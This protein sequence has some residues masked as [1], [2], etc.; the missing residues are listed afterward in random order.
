ME[1]SDFRIYSL[2]EYAR[3]YKALSIIPMKF[4]LFVL[5]SV[6]IHLSFLLFVPNYFAVTKLRIFPIE[7]VEP[8]QLY[9]QSFVKKV[10]EVERPKEN[11]GKQFLADPEKKREDF[12]TSKLKEIS[13]GESVDVPSPS[14]LVP[15]RKEKITPEERIKV[16]RSSPF[17]KDLGKF[18]HESSTP[19]GD[20]SGKRVSI[21]VE[22]M[23]ISRERIVEDRGTQ[24]IMDRMIGTT[25]FRNK[26]LR[27]PGEDSP[28]IKGP[29]GARSILYKPEIPEVKVDREGEIELKF[30][31]LPDGSVGRVLPV[32][33]GDA[34]LERIAISYL[35]Q[36]RFDRLDTSRSR[37]EQ[38]GTVTVKF[39][40]E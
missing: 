18:F 22:K 9:L 13:L 38:W 24:R 4:I 5:V 27:N 28:G 14:F 1:R 26:P 16:L 36:W 3:L 7:L 30:W 17:F 25:Q 11:P 12:I 31:V 15:E 40:L 8:K 29:A 34:E 37:V 35:K 32:I 6:F 10:K 33:K 2:F 21:G 39:R 20:R 23:E 19:A